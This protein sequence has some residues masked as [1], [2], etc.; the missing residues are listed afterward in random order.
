VLLVDR[1]LRIV[2][3]SRFEKG[4]A[5]E[6]V[7]GRSAIEHIP[8]EFQ[9]A[10]REACRLAFE[11]GKKSSYETA[12]HTPQGSARYRT[13]VG[14]LRVDGEIRYASM[15][16]HDISPEYQTRVALAEQQRALQ[17]SEERFRL[18]VESSPEAIVIYDT[19]AMRFVDVNPMAVEMFGRSRAELLTLGPADLSPERQPDG[20]D[21]AERA[22]AMLEAA[23]AGE[24]PVF[25]WTHQDA[26]GEPIDCEVRLL[27]LPHAEHR[28]V[29]GSITDISA[30]K[31]AERENEALAEQLAHAQRMQ[32]VG[33]L[34]GGLAHDFTNLLTVVG[35][36]AALIE[37][38]PRDR[39]A[40][41]RHAQ[42][43]QHAVARAVELTQRML[44]FSRQVSLR[45]SAV[46]VALLVR[47]ME[48]LLERTLGETTAVE[49]DNPAIRA[50]VDR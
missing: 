25:E 23:D 18:L 42:A 40:V 27:R 12:V 48:G 35:A 8:A 41:L 46:D 32:A 6:D 15:M 20:S 29:R 11:E 3:L 19:D 39:A 2:Y 34:T 45:P 26:E 49:T 47:E 50:M 37:L 16:S 22:R 10:V 43:I 24:R 44:A 14:P 31:R 4:F 7:I 17:Q 36:S 13:W 9:P 21:S 1:E 38:D 33:Q 28:W 5:R 30:R